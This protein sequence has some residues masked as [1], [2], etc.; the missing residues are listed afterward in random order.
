[1]LETIANDDEAKLVREACLAR[2]GQLADGQ[3]G[4]N[5]Q[6][7]VRVDAIR[8]RSAI[9]GRAQLDFWAEDLELAGY[10]R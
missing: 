8:M 9:E 2:L 4:T 1:V 6:S 7:A 5:A 10:R 3:R